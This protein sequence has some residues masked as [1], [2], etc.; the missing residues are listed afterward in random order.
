M[1]LVTRKIIGF[2]A[3][4]S[5]QITPAAGIIK[6]ESSLDVSVHHEEFHT[7]EDLVDGIPQN[8]WCEDTRD[9]E[10]I[11][12]VIVRGTTSTEARRHQINVHHCFSAKTAHLG[13]K[14]GSKK[15]GGGSFN[16]AELRQPSNAFSDAADDA[17]SSHKP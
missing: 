13:S 3:F 12:T 15:G 5:I 4:C 1:C 14:S 9:K 8:W 16:R 11:L 10:V 2:L 17:R 6:P 7:L